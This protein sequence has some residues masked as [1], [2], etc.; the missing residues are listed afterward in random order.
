MC[1]PTLREFT[2]RLSKLL[3]EMNP[4]IENIGMVYPAGH[5]E[6]MTRDAAQINAWLDADERLAIHGIGFKFGAAKMMVNPR[7]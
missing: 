2:L 7:R 1:T 6:L 3:Y 5:P 4:Q